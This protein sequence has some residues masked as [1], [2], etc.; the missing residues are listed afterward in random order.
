MENAIAVSE[1]WSLEIINDNTHSHNFKA[2]LFDFDGT[3]SLIRS[4]WQ[5]VMLPYFCEE[6]FCSLP[7]L[8]SNEAEIRSM[9]KEFIDKL[10]GKQTIFQCKQLKDE[11]EK[12]G[13]TAKEAIEYKNEY[14]RRLLL[15]ISN[16]KNGLN[17]KSIS[18]SDYIVR[19]AN[20]FLDLLQN[21]GLKLYCAS[22]TDQPQVRDEAHL[23][24]LDKYFGDNIYGALDEYAE[25]CSKEVVIKNLLE[26][27]GIK[28]EELLSFGDGFVEIELVKNAGG[29]AV[30]VATDELN[31]CGVDTEKRLRLLSAGADAVIP[32]FENYNE[33]FEFLFNNKGE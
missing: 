32:D 13:G 11:I 6:F 15:K 10:T 27:H 14:I 20:N 19:G 29:F 25:Q 9:I 18:S 12:R 3:L 17:D 16:T 2:V 31:K 26:K 21:A 5:D 22:G 8:K 28:G 4:G 1:K 7:E 23:L 24:G 33:L 30:A